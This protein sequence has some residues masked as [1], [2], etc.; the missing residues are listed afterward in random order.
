LGYLQIF[1]QKNLPANL[2][3]ATP[4]THVIGEGLLSLQT[5]LK[6]VE[7][8]FWPMSRRLIQRTASQPP[9]T[10]GSIMMPIRSK[11]MQSLKSLRQHPR[12][13]YLANTDGALEV[14]LAAFGR[15]TQFEETQQNL[16]Y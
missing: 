3:V 15:E 13:K 6:N 8:L 4:I 2:H 10:C 12:S 5:V 14:S 9:R 16:Y 7:M 1:V 11:K